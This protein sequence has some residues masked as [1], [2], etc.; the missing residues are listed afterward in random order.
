MATDEARDMS[1]Q[2]SLTT[3]LYAPKDDAIDGHWQPSV[4]TVI[5]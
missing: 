4:L 3:R 5:L 1:G 2:F